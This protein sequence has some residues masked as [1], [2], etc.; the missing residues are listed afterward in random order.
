MSHADLRVVIVAVSRLVE[1]LLKDAL[2]R[3]GFLTVEVLHDLGEFR[4]AIAS[5]DVV[6]V[7]MDGEDLPAD[8]RS[9]LAE[10]ARV[11]VLGIEETHG[12]AF[13]YELHPSRALEQPTPEELV[14]AIHHAVAEGT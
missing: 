7:G 1:G 14:A 3:A 2:R 9:Y 6:V 12:R 11:K 8:W 13:L 5:A 4:R 10:R